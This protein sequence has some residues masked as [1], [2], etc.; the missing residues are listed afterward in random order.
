[1]FLFVLVLFLLDSVHLQNLS[2]INYVS[3]N[4]TEHLL[5]SSV[6]ADNLSQNTKQL[7]YNGT[8]LIMSNVTQYVSSSAQ[9]NST[10][11]VFKYTNM[12][13]SGTEM[14]HDTPTTP[15]T[16]L[17]KALKSLLETTFEDDNEDFEFT[18]FTDD[19]RDFELFFEENVDNVLQDTR[20]QFGWWNLFGEQ[21][22][23]SS[24]NVNSTNLIEYLNHTIEMALDSNI[25]D[26]LV[27]EALPFAADQIINQLYIID[28]LLNFAMF[29]TILIVL[30]V[31]YKN[32]R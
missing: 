5:W 31:F 1:M 7:G 8:T 16:F 14:I 29:L 17:S 9:D 10:E 21:S 32:I 12:T 2:T 27:K 26:V 28:L 13:A 19:L 15:K 23:E 3:K 6:P 30:I 11:I 18:N 24:T 22:T 20:N 25:D 4:F